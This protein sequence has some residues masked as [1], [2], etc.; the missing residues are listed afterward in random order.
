MDNAKKLKRG[1]FLFKEGDL[2]DKVYLVQSGK[3]GLM[4]ERGSKRLEITTL[5]ASQVLG[6]SGLFTTAKYPFSAEALQETKVLEV[7]IEIMKQ[8]FEKSPPGIK[9]LV[10]SLVEE[11][12]HTIQQL[13]LS[14]MEG[15]KL[16]CPQGIVHRLFT[17]VHLVARHIGKHEQPAGLTVVPNE[18]PVEG[19][20]APLPPAAQ[21]YILLSWASFKLYTTRFFGESHQRM[22]SIFELL[23]KLKLAELQYGKNEEGEED[24][25]YIKLFNLQVYED[26]AEFYQYHLFKGSRAEAIFVDPLALKVA[27]AMFEVSAGAEV[28]HKGASTLEYS[29][30]L[31]E[32][33]SKHGFDLKPT[34]LDI[35]EKKGLFVQRKSF[36]DGR[37]TIAFDRTEF[38]KMAQYWAIIHEIDKWNERGSVDLNEKEAAVAAA[39]C[40]CSECKTPMVEKHKFCPNCGAKMAA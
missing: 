10:K 17:L 37:M 22:R 23:S 38:G 34:H 3:I 27:K 5:G 28:N 25:Q 24:L 9:L 33:K 6:E 31:A 21:P 13:K 15:E 14:K 2:P 32:C 40:A 19:V 20:A 35:L 16:P 26:F 30:V 7:P 11:I 36:D 8:Q 1:E 29:A 18:P 12:R 39:S 4:L